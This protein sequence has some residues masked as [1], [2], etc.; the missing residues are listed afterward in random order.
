MWYCYWGIIASGPSQLTEQ[1]T[2]CVPTNMYTYTY[3]EIFLCV[4]ICICIKLNMN[5]C[6]LPTLIHYRMDHS[7][8]LSC[9]SEISHCNCK[10]PGFYHSLSIYL[11]VQSHYIYTYAR[12]HSGFRI[13]KAF[14]YGKQFNQLEDSTYVQL[15]LSLVLQ[16]PFIYKAT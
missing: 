14:V 11:I 12:I 16:T 13:G 2:V 7:N 1:G 10:K 5:S 9:F 6:C 15:L 4:T 3:P 8:L